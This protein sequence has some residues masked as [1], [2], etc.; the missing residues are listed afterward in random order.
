MCAALASEPS[1]SRQVSQSLQIIN[2]AGA[3]T[4]L[5][6][7]LDSDGHQGC[8][9]HL[10]TIHFID[11]FGVQTARTHK[12]DAAVRLAEAADSRNQRLLAVFGNIHPC[13]KRIH[14]ERVR[15]SVE[16]APRNDMMVSVV[17][18]NLFPDQ[19]LILLREFGQ[20][21]FIAEGSGK[22]DIPPC[23]KRACSAR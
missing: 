6:F 13:V 22:R 16:I 2:T 20:V 3:V 7:H 18:R 21:E 11:G 19:S 15:Q 4:R 10:H 5:Q 1:P 9:G 23:G 14:L 17:I 12:P 8:T